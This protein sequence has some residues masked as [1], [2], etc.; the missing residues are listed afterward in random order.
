MKEETKTPSMHS[1]ERMEIRPA[2]NGGHVV[3]H[4]MKSKPMHSSKMGM[5]MQ[6][7]EP[8][9]HVFGAGEGHEMLAH[10]AN[11]LDIAEMHEE[12][13]DDKDNDDGVGADGEYD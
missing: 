11:H 8:E 3:T 2:E 7:Q 12:E 13:S 9:T 5:G 4:H 6:Y 10:V 1:I